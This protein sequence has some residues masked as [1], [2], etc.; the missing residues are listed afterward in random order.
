MTQNQRT[1]F[2]TNATSSGRTDTTNTTVCTGQGQRTRDAVIEISHRDGTTVTTFTTL[3]GNTRATI[4]TFA[5]G[6]GNATR[7]CNRSGKRIGCCSNGTTNA[8]ILV[9]GTITITTGTTGDIEVGNRGRPRVGVLKD[10]AT[11]AASCGGGAIGSRASLDGIGSCHDVPGKIGF[12]NGTTNAGGAGI[13]TQHGQCLYGGVAGNRCQRY[14]ASVSA[15]DGVTT[16]DGQGGTRAD[17]IGGD[18]ESRTPRVGY[19]C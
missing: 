13:A 15:G 6:Y 19:N 17:N 7:G 16:L 4:T 8:T 18:I 12:G 9:C 5:G 2:T 3:R 11:D 14:G 10:R 1:T